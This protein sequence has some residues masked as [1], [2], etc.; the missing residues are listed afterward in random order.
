MVSAEGFF[1]A[2][3]GMR[4]EKMKKIKGAA[5]FI[6]VVVVGHVLLEWNGVIM[7]V[8]AIAPPVQTTAASQKTEDDFRQRKGDGEVDYGQ[9]LTYLGEVFHVTEEDEDIVD[10]ILTHGSALSDGK[11]LLFESADFEVKGGVILQR[12]ERTYDGTSAKLRVD[13]ILRRHP[14]LTKEQAQLYQQ[15]M[16]QAG[17]TNDKLIHQMDMWIKRRGIE[18]ALGWLSQ[19]AMEMQK[20]E[21]PRDDALSK[22]DRDGEEEKGIPTYGYHRVDTIYE[23]EQPSWMERQPHRVRFLLEKPLR[24]RTL[25]ELKVLGKECYNAENAPQKTTRQR[26]F[27][28]LTNEQKTVFW[29][30]Y[31]LMQAHLLRRIPLGL[32]ARAF[33]AKI[34]G[35]KSLARLKGIGSYLF[36]VS[37]GTVRVVNPP[38]FEE[39]TIIFGAY[40]EAKGRFE[41]SVASRLLERAV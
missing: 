34:K 15:Y 1:N 11:R 21:T 6:L 38:S 4:N 12:H 29:D 23:Q 31:H 16:L 26:L 2:E 8:G 28:T 39:W 5:G 41:S 27:T 3:C 19:M 30:H 14:S 36:R 20:L 18:P 9:R 35:A 17:W 40:H 7:E 13:T 22:I 24:C 37:K 32:T 25:K 10:A 33:L